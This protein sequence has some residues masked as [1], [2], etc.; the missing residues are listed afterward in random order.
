MAAKVFL[1]VS[2]TKIYQFKAND[3]EIKRYPLCLRNVSGDFQL[4]TWKEQD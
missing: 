2:A 1:F 3:S 4:I